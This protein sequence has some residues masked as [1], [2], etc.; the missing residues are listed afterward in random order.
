MSLIDTRRD[1]MFPVLSALQIET[2]RRFA[3]G[4]AQRFA[5]GEVVFEVGERQ[6][7]AWLVLEGEIQV[8][9]RD[10]RGREEPIATEGVG[11]FSGKLTSSPGAPHWRP[12]GQVRRGRPLCHST[13]LTCERL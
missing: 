12:A 6:A 8:I 9:R 13:P 11:Q 2:A 1:Q 7:P 5:P 10:G 4:E 3:S